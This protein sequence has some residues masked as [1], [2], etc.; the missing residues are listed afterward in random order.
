M[1]E[2][3]EQETPQ[4]R[5]SFDDVLKD[6]LT[7]WT[8]RF[9]RALEEQRQE[10]G[11]EAEERVSNMDRATLE[12]LGALEEAVAARSAELEQMAR[13]HRAAFDE[14]VAG[15]ATE[16]DAVGSNQTDAI[17]KVASDAFEELE[18][19]A[20]SQV[21]RIEED[22]RAIRDDVRKSVAEGTTDFEKFAQKRLGELEDALRARLESFR[23]ELIDL[24]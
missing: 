5:R 16:L 10:L 1:A 2:L 24:V 15:R 11:R 22:T 6:A 7:Q 9:E 3:H 4:R 18:E 20:A 8:K 21:Q 13:Q 12:H 19:R 23:R 14:A 17:V